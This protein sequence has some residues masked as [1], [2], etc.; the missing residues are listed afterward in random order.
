MITIGDGTVNG[1]ISIATDQN[2][3][4]SHSNL[5]HFIEINSNAPNVSDI[6]NVVITLNESGITFSLY[7]DSTKTVTIPWVA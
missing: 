6:N 5:Q 2:I 3:N 4:I 7:N 1:G